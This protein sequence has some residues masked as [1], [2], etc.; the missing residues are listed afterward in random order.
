LGLKATPKQTYALG[1][2]TLL[3]KY[4]MV[5][6]D[7]PMR[8]PP[9]RGMQHVNELDPAKG[10]TVVRPYQYGQFQKFEIE[11]LVEKHLEVG[12]ITP[13]KSPYVA[14]VI[15]ARK[16]DAHYHLYIDYKALI[17]TTIKNKFHMLCIDDLVD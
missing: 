6:Q 11:N 17:Q 12:I 3:Q 14:L 10:S 15:L 4:K 13:S 9:E 5:F 2:S 8:H 7:M 16:K 1:L